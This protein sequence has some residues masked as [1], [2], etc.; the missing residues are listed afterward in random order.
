[1]S[2]ESKKITFIAPSLKDEN[3]SIAYILGN[4]VW[5]MIHSA[6]HRKMPLLLILN[7]IYPAIENKQYLL[8]MSENSNPVFYMAWANFNEEEE[9]KYIEHTN[10]ALTPNNWNCGDRT[11]ILF[12]I[13]PFGYS[14]QA[15][16][17]VEDQLFA[18]SPEV[19]FMYHESKK[20]ES[21]IIAKRGKNVLPEE[22][23]KWHETHLPQTEN[24]P[25]IW[26]PKDF[27]RN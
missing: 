14:Y 27:Y 3:Y 8:G 19:R 16:R 21:R 7:Q 5:L 25:K 26:L 22:S 11:W 15:K 10:S 23:H 12:W 1:M 17:F 9:A 24:A 6:D 2:S 20:R 4:I 13:S 18:D